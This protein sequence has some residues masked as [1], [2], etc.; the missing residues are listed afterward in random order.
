VDT[1]LILIGV[2]CII[3]GIIGGGVKLVQ[4]ELSPVSS[5]WRQLLLGIFGI[6]LVVSGLIS[7]GHLA[8]LN[9]ES[10]RAP[11]TIK[12]RSEASAYPEKRQ[13]TIAKSDAGGD[14][15][16]P[17][18]NVLAIPLP[19]KVDI[20]WCVTDDGGASNE[21]MAQQIVSALRA[22]RRIGLVRARPL[23]QSTN[24]NPDYRIFSNIVRF[25]PGEQSGA[26]EIARMASQTSGASFN[27]AHALPGSPSI[28]YLSVFVC[29]VH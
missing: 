4:V 20:F 14:Q 22:T 1:T 19:G 5:L 17:I 6:I 15:K 21:A 26:E 8:F 12:H 24:A 28:N 13:D 23:Q 9:P 16:A 27:A 7:G 29:A 11:E 18:K 3:G 2:G 25:D 10:M